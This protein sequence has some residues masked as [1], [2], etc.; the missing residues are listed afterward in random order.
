M[1]F[2]QYIAKNTQEDNVKLNYLLLYFFRHFG[3]GPI[4]LI[5]DLP[6]FLKITEYF[7]FY[8]DTNAFFKVSIIGKSALS[9]PLYCFWQVMDRKYMVNRWTNFVLL[10]ICVSMYIRS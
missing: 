3:E 7:L 8:N 4:S 1:K 10:N 2:P 5:L 6:S 9:T